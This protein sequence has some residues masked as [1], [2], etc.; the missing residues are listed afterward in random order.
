[1]R[2]VEFVPYQK[3][4]RSVIVNCIQDA[5]KTPNRSTTTSTYLDTLDARR[6]LTRGSEMLQFWCDV[7]GIDY[8]KLLL[9]GK[10]MEA[11]GWDKSFIKERITRG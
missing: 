8:G 3:L 4:A 11:F 7:A 5:T 10:K 6:E 9:F 2:P 1:M